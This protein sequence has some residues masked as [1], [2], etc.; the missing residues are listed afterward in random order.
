MTTTRTKFIGLAVFALVALALAP[1]AA[2]RVGGGESFGGGGGGD[3]DILDLVFLFIWLLQLCIEY[4]AVGIP[5]TIIVII[6]LIVG[7]I[8]GKRKG[9]DVVQTRTIRKA[10]RMADEAGRRASE[11]NMQALKSRD[12]AFSETA[13]VERTKKAFLALQG[14]WSRQDLAPVRQFISAGVKERFDVQFEIQRAQGY[15]NRMEDV[16][17][18]SAEIAS[19]ASDR[20]FDTMN[21]F[22]TATAKDDYVD[23]KTGAV[24]RHNPDGPFSEY[25]T[26]M[27]RPGAKTLAGGGL[28]E[29]KCPNCG[30]GLALS[31]TGRC[32][33]CNAA[34]ASGEYDWVLT[35]ITQESEWSGPSDPERIPG[36]TPMSAKDPVFSAPNIEDRASVVFWRMI[37][38]FFEADAGPLAS[39]ALPVYATRLSASFS[40]DP[41]GRSSVLIDAAVG[42]VELRNIVPGGEDGF[43][44]VEVLLTWSARDAKRGPDGAV[45]DAGERAIRHQYYTLVRRS[46]V[47]TPEKSS[48]RIAPCPG[49]GAPDEGG[50]EGAC[51][52]CRAPTNDGSR[53]WALESVDAFSTTSLAASVRPEQAPVAPDVVLSAMAGAMVADGAVDEREGALLQAFAKNKGI[54]TER[55]GQIIAAARLGAALPVPASREEGKQALHAIARVTLADG[56]IS[57]DE[58]ALLDSYGGRLGYS[59]ADVRHAVN[60]AKTDLYQ[61]AKQTIRQTRQGGIQA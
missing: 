14:A 39:A 5:L 41:D 8:T 58:W 53:D 56:S 48:F 60:A 21:V 33:H 4:P 36:Y 22:V 13:F 52:Y 47:G 27:R 1:P 26:F 59:R 49:C 24:V 30:A 16:Q 12:P 23:L 55:L 10:N 9:T 57:K 37:K 20:H 29:G 38:A 6:V 46:S 42:S 7:A 11:R 31:D 28:V 43:D 50:K 18:Q 2:A 45:S 61:E 44:R 15:R 40:K 34:V 32:G 51:P 54:T 17:I 35:E 3:G 25:W 19:V